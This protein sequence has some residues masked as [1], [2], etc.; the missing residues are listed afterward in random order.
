MVAVIEYFARNGSLNITNVRVK[1]E[2]MVK[3]VDKYW[4]S[5]DLSYC[6]T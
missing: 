3:V 6:M 4:M 1:V 2:K 5:L